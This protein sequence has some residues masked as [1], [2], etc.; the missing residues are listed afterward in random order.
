MRIPHSTWL[1]FTYH[2]QGPPG[3]ARPLRL[4]W[5]LVAIRWLGIVFVGF[6]IVLMPLDEGRRLACFGVLAFAAIYNLVV[7]SMIQRS[8]S[9]TRVGVVTTFSDSVLSLG[10]LYLIDAGFSSPFAVLLFSVTVSVAMRYGYKLA[11]IQCTSLVII[12]AVEALIRTHQLDSLFVFFSAYLFIVSLLASYL[13]EEA[14]RA[15]E[16]LQLR[17]R[18]ANQLNE[19]SGMLATTLHLES[20]LHAVTRASA[21]L[22]ESECAVLL[23]GSALLETRHPVPSLITYPAGSG[24]QMRELALLCKQD[25]GAEATEL[26]LWQ[27]FTLITGHSGI[28]VRLALQERNVTFA[29]L[30]LALPRGKVASTIDP[31]LVVAFAGRAMLALENASLYLTLTQNSDELQRAY[32]ELASAHQELLSVDEMKTNFLANVS[33][34][35][36]TPLTSIRSFSELLL[37]FDDPSVRQEFLQIINLESE[38]LTRL[39][40]DVLDVTKIESGYMEWHMQPLD[41]PALLTESVRVFDASLTEQGLEMCIEVAPDLPAVEADAD[42]IRQ[43]LN[44]LVSN[45]VK[46]TARGS[47]KL[48]AVRAGDAVRVSVRDTGIGI[49][50]EDQERIFEKFQQVGEVLTGKPRGSGLGLPISREI[51]AHHGGRLWVESTLAKGSTFS[52][53]LPISLDHQVI[54]ESVA[55]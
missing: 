17:L 18:R 32:G 16:A 4:E 31:D 13:R 15:E 40:N 11:L 39:V 37:S 7:R 33:H 28:L 52:F 12:D 19:A 29:T 1:S 10:F 51:I 50:D 38:R 55:A 8:A 9:L 45:A 47:I 21:H 43:V 2:W 36:R 3:L 30:A 27:P 14:S 35:L 5:R 54:G 22:F 6:G 46:F 24:V 44:N 42:R 49:P 41:L 34:E 48:S 20:L 25:A 53:T 23:P 26:P